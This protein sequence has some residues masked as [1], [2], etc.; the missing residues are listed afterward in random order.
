[1]DK[2]MH[3]KFCYYSVSSREEIHS[4]EVEQQIKGQP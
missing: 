2:V 1:M 3:A 4:M